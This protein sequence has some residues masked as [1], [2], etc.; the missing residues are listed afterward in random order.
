MLPAPGKKSAWTEWVAE[1]S[2]D[3][4]WKKIRGEF[5]VPDDVAYLNNGTLGLSP[6]PVIEAMYRHLLETESVKTRK[7]PEYPWW[8]YGATLAIREALGNFISAAADEIALTRNATEAMNTVATGLDLNP[9]DE[10]LMS[11][12]EHPGGRSA[13]YQRA[14]RY[15][16]VVREFQIPLPPQ[17]GVEILEKVQ[18]AVTP[19]TRVISVSHITTVTGGIL[20]VKE[21]SSLARAR[22]IITLIDG[23]HAIGQIPLD[24]HE[25]GCDYY[26]SSP[27]KWL[28]APKGTGLLYCRKG[29]A[30]RL[31]S[32]TAA[33][34]WD[35][36]KLGCER[37][38][39]VGTS[40][41][42]LLMGLM[43]AIDFHKKIGGARIFGRERQLTEML[44]SRLAEIRGVWFGNGQ[45]PELSAAMVKAMLPV[46]KIE[47][48]ARKLW[49]EHKIWV[50]A[51]DGP[52]KL[53]ASMRF[54]CPIYVTENDL[55]RTID[56]L[57]RHLAGNTVSSV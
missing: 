13:W 35:Q 12:Q 54:S 7:Y 57:K 31:W 36:A 45:P 55:N 56:L 28:Y 40:N 37:L 10:V 43:A 50:V 2:T 34:T 11:N 23:A 19:K 20:P 33:G 3:D 29:M 21:I 16:I 25:I 1:P 52:D 51:G 14:K 5:L 27:H 44:R 4:Y 53:P 49:E 47:A 17:S 6:R 8:G 26:A 9:G 39:N 46:Q 18:A 42:T 15:G 22:G 41:L 32:H 48:F 24:M 30:E 38:T